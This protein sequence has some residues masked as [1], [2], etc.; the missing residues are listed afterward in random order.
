[1]DLKLNLTTQ[2]ILGQVLSS[3]NVSSTL[4]SDARKRLLEKAMSKENF[5]L[6]VDSKEISNLLEN[7]KQTKEKEAKF[8]LETF[9]KL[10][11]S[12]KSDETGLKA[13]FL[14][15]SPVLKQK[16]GIQSENN[17]SVKSKINNENVVRTERK[18]DINDAKKRNSSQRS[19]RDLMK[20]NQFRS[21]SPY[22]KKAQ[23]NAISDPRLTKV[24]NDLSLKKISVIFIQELKKT[25]LSQD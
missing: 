12:L 9:S 15:L 5:A 24:I 14:P 20:K 18:S 23:E 22:L 11:P 1:M 8:K 16:R 17:S 25:Q 4:H 13:K 2:S 21:I 3:K 10:N 19:C 6:I 7:K